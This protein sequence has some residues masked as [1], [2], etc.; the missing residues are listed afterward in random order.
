[1]VGTLNSIIGLQMSANTI[2]YVQD[3][4]SISSGRYMLGSANG[5]GEL[6]K[7]PLDL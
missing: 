6:S 4:P 3:E 2:H 1:V 7:T 5:Q